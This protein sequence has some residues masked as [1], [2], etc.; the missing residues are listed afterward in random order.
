MSYKRPPSEPIAI[1]GSSCRFT[2]DVTSPSKLWSLL[3]DPTDLSKDVPSE[4]FSIKGFYHED[5]EY[6]G[7]TNSPKA[8]WLD[9]DHRA[10]DASFFS[11]TPKEAEAI[12]PQQR[13][14]LEVVYEALESADYTLQQYAGQKVAVFA[15]VM[16]ADYDTLSQRDDLTASQYY[17][18]GNARSI[19]SNRISYFFN[20]RGP[21]MTIDTACSSSLVALHQ[22]VLSL[23]SGESTMACVTGANL[24]MTPE[25]FIV[26]SSLH[27]LSPTGH[28]RMWDVNADGY[29]RGEGIAALFIKPLSLALADGDQIQAIIRETGANSDGR[30][31]GITMPNPQAQAALIRDTYSR[32]GLDPL[33]PRDRCQYFEAHGT[34]TQAGDPREAAAIDEAFFSGAD[35]GGAQ[36][37]LDEK[38]KLFVGSIKTVIGHT[39]GAAG[40]AGVLKVVLGMHNGAIPPNLHLEQLNPSVAPFCNH[41]HVPTKLTAWPAAPVGHPLRASVNSFGF[42]GTN[43]HAILE[44]YEPYIHDDVVRFFRSGLQLRRPLSFS[45]EVQIPVNLPL[46]LSANSQQSLAARITLY[47]DYL[48]KNPK[49]TLQD[50]AWHLFSSRTAH[51]FKLAITGRSASA[52]TETLNTLIEKSIQSPSL[53]LGTRSRSIQD[54]PN[55]LGIFTG[56]GAQWA[57]MSKGLLETSNA[58]RNSIKALDAILQACPD[59]PNWTLEGEILA[60]KEVSQINVAAVSQPLCTALQIALVDLLRSLGISFHCVVGHSS[61]EIAAAYAAGRLNARDAILISY[62]RGLYAHLAK[63]KRFEKGGML[64]VGFPR[65]E[66]KEFCQKPDYIGRICVA[67]SN[68]PSSVTLSGDLDAIHQAN[69]ILSRQGMFTRLLVVDTAYHSPHMVE[70][71]IH[72]CH[73]LESCNISPSETGNGTA[74]ISSVYRSA[75]DVDA[76]R[77]KSSYWIDNMTQPVLFYEAVQQAVQKSQQFGCV[78]EVGPHPALK[79]P[80]AQILKDTKVKSLP[81]ASLLDRTK[82]DSIAFSDFLGFM[83]TNFGPSSV[84]IRAFVQHSSQPGLV[85]S[86]LDGAP[87]YCWDHSQIHYRESRISRQYHHRKDAPHELLGVRTRDDSDFEMRWRNILKLDKIPWIEHHKFQRQPLL[88]ASA[89]CVLALDA[90]QTILD[91]RAASIVELEDLEFLS[92][93]IVEPDSYGVEIL[94]SLTMLSPSRE[95]HSGSRIEAQFS[96]TSV[97]VTPDGSGPMRKNFQ[98]RMRIQLEEPN[99]HALPSRTT[100]TRAETLP[101]STDAFYTMMSEIGLDYSGPFRALTSLERRHNFSSAVLQRMHPEETS[102]LD[103]SPAM[104]DSCL[105][106]AFATFSSPGDKYVPIAPGSIFPLIDA[107]QFG[108]LFYHEL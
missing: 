58:Y 10:F 70:P 66:A 83:W 102:R 28:C 27:M 32:T 47:R 53:E 56:Q 76:E 71:A 16:T 37:V 2:G 92:G 59:P 33:D 79:G 24:M 52:V 57:N 25:Q 13:M 99:S 60:E 19:I 14:L 77:L 78:V 17:A 86:R 55:I 49:L 68:G 104:L 48:I 38:Q 30:T 89:Y 40:L 4:R 39:E 100:S 97:A 73:A 64:A 88:P 31:R 41:L 84:D 61:G 106:S 7:T 35:V 95:R 34:G 101:V 105:Q 90:A 21:S 69:D 9:Q 50:V 22:A 29:A 1:I 44:K 91:G 85:Y 80:T 26:E 96:L 62:Y 81:Y 6:H 98:G 5:G 8:Y 103:I 82:D 12:D 65:A 108:L 51:A 107:G 75:V 11:I 72:Y 36:S 43:A 15:G 18:T 23:R 54:K 45:G 74:W 93:I 87:S 46:L 3:S 42:G 94:F 67:A 20:F 63:G